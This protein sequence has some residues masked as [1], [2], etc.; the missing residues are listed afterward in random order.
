[1]NASACGKRPAA[2]SAAPASIPD[3]KIIMNQKLE[4]S[5]HFNQKLILFMEKPDSK[6]ISKSYHL[7][8]LFD[9]L[10]AGFHLEKISAVV[11]NGW[12]SRVSGPRGQRCLSG[13]LPIYPA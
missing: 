3:E 5:R 13:S 11:A 10:I 2:P 4:K 6:P 9:I 8:L 7:G 1:M 12:R